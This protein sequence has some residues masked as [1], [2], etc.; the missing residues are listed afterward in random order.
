MPTF[1]FFPLLKPR[2]PPPPH[3]DK[4]NP[5]TSASQL[6]SP[7]FPLFFQH[8]RRTGSKKHVSVFPLLPP[9]ASL[10]KIWLSLSPLNPSSFSP[11][12][13]RLPRMQEDRGSD[14]SQSGFFSH[15]SHPFRNG[16]PPSLPLL[17]SRVGRVPFFHFP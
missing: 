14:S 6:I 2:T 5:F 4:E 11:S 12:P 16:S 10:P 15:W 3:T 1:P 8:A 7:F 13:C 17:L 9:E